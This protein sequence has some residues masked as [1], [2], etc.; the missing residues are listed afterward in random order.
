MTVLGISIGTARTGIAILED[1]RIL[2]RQVHVY[3]ATWTENKLR[4]ITNKYREHVRRHNVTAIIVKIPPLSR[5]S[6]AVSR[7]IRSVEAIAK[8]TYCDF[9][10]VTKNEIKDRLCLSSTEEMVK[11]APMLYQELLPLYKE[12]LATGHSFYKKIYEA[13]LAAHI[14]AERQKLKAAT[15]E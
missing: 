12:G 6:K 10:L 3:Q 8:E 5:H 9:D 2:E 14:Y 4:I 1:G 13:V 15:K 7:L 11:F